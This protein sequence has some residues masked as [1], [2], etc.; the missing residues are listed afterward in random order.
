MNRLEDNNPELAAGRVLWMKKTR[1][2]SVPVK[3]HPV[4]N[5]GE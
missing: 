2:S 4:E 3:Y 1:P 5:A